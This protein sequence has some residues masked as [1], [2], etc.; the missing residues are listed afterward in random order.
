MLNDNLQKAINALNL[1]HGE[2]KAPMLQEKL[3]TDILENCSLIG[4]N[5][6]LSNYRKIVRKN[7]Y[8]LVL[9]ITNQENES[10]NDCFSDL[11][12][13]CDELLQSSPTSCDFRCVKAAKD[14]AFRIL[15]RRVKHQ[16]P[17]NP[18]LLMGEIWRLD[19]ILEKLG[20]HRADL[21]ETVDYIKTE[22]AE[23]PEGTIRYKRHFFCHRLDW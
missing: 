6:S 19:C 1:L 16:Y 22:W 8:N 11:I 9:E 18:W 3:A 2:G 17:D 14:T 12:K 13:A 10:W 15:K 21:G 5:L 4:Q 7:I 23:H 20:C